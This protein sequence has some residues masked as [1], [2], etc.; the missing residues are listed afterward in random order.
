MRCRPNSPQSL[1]QPTSWAAA[2]LIGNSPHQANV[3][4]GYRLPVTGQARP[5]I[6]VQGN[7]IRPRRGRLSASRQLLEQ[8]E[9]TGALGRPTPAV[10]LKLGVDMPDVNFDRVHRQVKFIADFA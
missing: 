3:A 7:A 1:R 2:G 8:T 5:D 10:N 6:P 4:A 9:S